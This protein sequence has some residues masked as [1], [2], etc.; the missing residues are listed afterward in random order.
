MK[1]IKKI[2]IIN[3]IMKYNKYIINNTNKENKK[4]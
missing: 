4:K 3:I 2:E 1:I